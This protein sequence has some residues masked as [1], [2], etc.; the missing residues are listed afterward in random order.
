MTRTKQNIIAIAPNSD[1]GNSIIF[2]NLK[3]WS[4]KHKSVKYFQNIPRS[5]YLGFLKNCAVL[6]G[7][8]SSGIVESTLFNI[9][10]IDLGIRQK[11]RERERSVICIEKPTSDKIFTEIMKSMSNSKIN[12]KTKIYGNGK[13]SKKILKYLEN[14]PM[15]KKLIQKQFYNN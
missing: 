5:E 15:N 7:N 9:Q 3:K 2:N 8:S 13:S 1:P 11:C 12:K 4:E 14:I 6:V 10:V